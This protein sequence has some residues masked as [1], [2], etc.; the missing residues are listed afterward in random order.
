ML[1][2]HLDLTPVSV[3]ELLNCIRL[4]GQQEVTLSEAY[5]ALTALCLKKLIY[6]GSGGLY[7]K[8]R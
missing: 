7:C 2:M 6:N 1:Y 3:D 8:K 5:T 4:D